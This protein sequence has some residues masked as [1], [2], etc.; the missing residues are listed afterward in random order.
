MS[1]DNTAIARWCHEMNRTVQQL[2]G[3]EMSPP[4]GDAP[5][6]MKKSAIIGV[7]AHKLRPRSPE[8]THQLWLD[9]KKAEG[10]RYGQV[11]APE[12]KEHP[13]IVPYA[14]LPK[15]QR[16]KGVIF[17]AVVEGLAGEYE[18]QQNVRATA[19]SRT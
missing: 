15:E 11:K 12:K 19:E 9:H 14:Q 13:C 1:Y 8:E 6:W 10:W 3:E 4:W 2:I 16:L 5:E 17:K 7:S 18:A